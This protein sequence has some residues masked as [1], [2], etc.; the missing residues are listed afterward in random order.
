MLTHCCYDLQANALSP[1][2]GQLIFASA[3]E[4]FINA[5]LRELINQHQD[6]VAQE[7]ESWDKKRESMK[8]DLM[9]EMKIEEDM[10]KSAVEKPKDGKTTTTIEDRK[11]SSASIGGGDGD[12][13]ISESAK[14]SASSAANGKNTSSKKKKKGKK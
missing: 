8:K 13:V 1:N 3:N 11:Q 5:N 10:K 12:S 6:T 4:M 9:E 7:K 14:S 2:W